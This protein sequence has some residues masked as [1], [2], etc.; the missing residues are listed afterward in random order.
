MKQNEAFSGKF[1]CT[2][3]RETGLV[4]FFIWQIY[5]FFNRNTA[6]ECHMATC[7]NFT[8]CQDSNKLLVYVY[9][10]QNDLRQSSLYRN[11]LKIIRAQFY[12]TSDPEKA[13]LF[14]P[15]IDTT[16]RDRIRLVK[17]FLLD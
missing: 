17:K 15:S 12:F 6:E 13:C 4:E 5:L 3:K 16:D 8:K 9:P 2:T 11:I 14:I 7:F 10:D 1:I